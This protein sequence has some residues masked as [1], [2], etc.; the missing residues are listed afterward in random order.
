MPTVITAKEKSAL[1]ANIKMNDT[2]AKMSFHLFPNPVK[3]KNVMLKVYT[4]SNGMAQWQL[5]TADGQLQMQQNLFLNAG[6]M[7]YPVTLKSGLVPGHYQ[8]KFRFPNGVIKT[9]TLQIV[10]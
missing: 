8:L 6:D 5:F 3:D 4:S 7:V 2:G 10:P 9:S 1:H